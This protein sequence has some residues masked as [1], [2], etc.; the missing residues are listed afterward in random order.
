MKI[1]ILIP[2]EESEKFYEKWAHEEDKIDFSAGIVM[3]KKT[4]DS[5]KKGETIAV[6]Y[7]SV[8]ND[9][10]VAEKIYLSAV[11]VSDSQIKTSP[12]IIDRV[13]K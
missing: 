6:M 8:T 4:G 13:I 10:S 2:Y 12:L 3:Q 11:K 9:F 1:N 5:V 7:S